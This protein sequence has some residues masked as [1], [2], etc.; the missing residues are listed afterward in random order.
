V[1]EQSGRP[2][3]REIVAVPLLEL[4]PG[5][6]PRL[7]G[8][9]KAHVARLAEIQEPLPPILVDRHSMRVIDGMHRLLAASRK[10]QQTIEVEF[11]EGSPADAF[12][13]AVEM[14]VRHGLPLSQVDRHAAAARIIAS[15]PYMSDG[16]I[17][18]STGLTGKTVAAI[19]RRSANPEARPPIRIG[20]DGRLRPVDSAPGR[21]RAAALLAQHPGASLREIARGAGI[22]PTTVRDVRRR[23]AR[24]DEPTPTSSQPRANAKHVAKPAAGRSCSPSAREE[25]LVPTAVLPRLL[26]DPSLRQSE[27]GRQLLRLL[28][29]NAVGPREWSEAIS[30]VPPHRAAIIADLARNYG[31]MWLDLASELDKRIQIIDALAASCPTPETAPVGQ[32]YSLTIL[33]LP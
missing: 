28:Q 11:F 26:Q 33:A 3:G 7:A 5:D 2:A 21:R 27:N 8:E 4:R 23:L 16:A 10:G 12:L 29:L 25:S 19:R 20:K 6:S 30:A 22:S 1:L 14:N 18:A 24:G 17:G 13:R 32:G 15:H 31:R 9:S